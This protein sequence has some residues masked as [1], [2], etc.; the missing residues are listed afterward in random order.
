MSNAKRS[1]VFIDGRNLLNSWGDYCF[2]QRYI[3][4][5]ST[6]GK[7]MPAKKI[8][9]KNLMEQITQTTDCIR[10]Y[11]YDGLPASPGKDLIKFHDMLRANSI[12]VV[13]KPLRYRSKI[14]KHCNKQDVDVPYQKGIDV[15]LVTEVM[16]LGFEN[17]YEIAIIVS[18]DND[19]EDAIRYIKSKGKQVWVV[20]FRNCL[21]GDIMRV[22][23]KVIFLDKL[24]SSI[25]L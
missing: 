7:E 19:F 15:A 24:F 12:T 6:T 25:T 21:G 22:A 5:N 3:K 14:C 23:D 11:Y 13:T 18:G 17:A 16:N 10:G 4:K 1:M 2:S 9:Y 20:S 8:S